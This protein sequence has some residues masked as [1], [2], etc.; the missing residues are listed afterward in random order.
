M[1]RIFGVLSALLLAMLPLRA[2]DEAA[3]LRRENRELRERLIRMER[4]LA[5]VRIWLGDA[6]SG[7]A[8]GNADGERRALLA[9]REFSRRGNRMAAEAAAAGEEFRALL[10][11]LALGPA[12]K[13]RLQLRLDALD[14]AARKF[15]ALSIPGADTVGSCR[16]L[17]V[18]RE[19]QVAVVSAGSGSGVAPGM[20]F[21]PV[22][23]PE[24]RLRVIGVRFDGA[25]VEPIAGKLDA[26]VPGTQL[27]ALTVRE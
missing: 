22:S 7:A 9:V 14:D 10:G 5:A 15:S 19:L 6:G 26:V 16:V 3:A 21:H 18:S 17:A 4:E 2:E 12:R 13:A 27:S 20:I 23:A 25:L 1:I 24:V 11:E 8:A